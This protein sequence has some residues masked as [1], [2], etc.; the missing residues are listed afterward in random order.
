MSV[1][2]KKALGQ[3]FLTD[4]EVVHQTVE[5]IPPSDSFNTLL[6]IGPGMGILTRELWKKHPDSLHVIEIDLESYEYLLNH[7]EI[8]GNRIHFGDFLQINLA[9]LFDHPIAIVGNFPYNISTQIIFKAIEH[10]HLVTS[11]TGMFQKEVAER[12]CASPGSKIYGITS[13]L[14]QA[15]YRTEYFFTIPP[16]RFYPPPKVDSGVIGMVRF[17]DELPRADHDSLATVVKAAFQQRRKTL[18]NALKILNFDVPE[19]F[20]HRR[21]ETLTVDEFITLAEIYKKK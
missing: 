14:V 2:P 15:Y 9:A 3:H 7:L 16:N 4:L 6:E 1:K 18:R 10:R 11:I 5:K 21:A 19:E 17:R 12:F 13:V 8:P 20:A